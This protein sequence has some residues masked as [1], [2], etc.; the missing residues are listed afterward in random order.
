MKILLAALF[1]AACMAAVSSPSSG[2]PGGPG[3]SD[4]T[5]EQAGAPAPLAS[6]G[7]PGQRAGGR[8]LVRAAIRLIAIV[9]ATLILVSALLL[10]FERRLIYFP[11]RDP[12]FSWQPPGLKVEECAFR[13]QDGLQ[14]Y[15]WW[16]P[17][18]GDDDPARRPVLLWCHGNA[19]NISHRAENLS[20]LADHGIAVMIFDYRGYGKSEGTPSEDGLYLDASAAYEY[21]IDARRI[22]PARIICFGRSL[23]AAVALHLAL[24]KKCAGLILES[25]FASMRAMARH[26]LPFPPAWLF[27]RSRFDNLDL[28]R[29]VTVPVFV[30]HGDRDELVPFEQGRE[31]F[32]AAPEPK[33]FYVIHGAGHNDT[34]V[35]GGADYFRAVR[36]FCE[37]CLS[38]AGSPGPS[39]AN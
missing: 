16:H 10:L 26:R 11:T 1:A 6:H 34:Y 24:E 18:R 32:D 4:Q 8:A 21:L 13:T 28:I 36:A 2:L 29:R 20:L 38:R 5:P 14:L 31:V 3:S 39:A 9:A 30:V 25:P 35:V 12:E 7:R 33:Q 17:G 15:G 23:G 27:M 37:S 19:G 22:E